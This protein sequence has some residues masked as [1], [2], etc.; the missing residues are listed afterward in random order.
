MESIELF[1]IS[2][3]ECPHLVHFEIGVKAQSSSLADVILQSAEVPAGSN[4]SGGHVLVDVG[5]V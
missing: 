1:N 4:D 5:G 3:V 2:S